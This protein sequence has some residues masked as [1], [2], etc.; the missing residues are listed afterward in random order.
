VDADV[1]ALYGIDLYTRQQL[2]DQLADKAGLLDSHILPALHR[3]AIDKSRDVTIHAAIDRL[4]RDVLA[5]SG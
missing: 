4:L 2:V 1:A 5:L 3:L